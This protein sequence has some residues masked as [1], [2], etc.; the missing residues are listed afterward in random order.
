MTK[1]WE[2]ALHDKDFL[3]KFQDMFNPWSNDLGIA[4]TLQTGVSTEVDKKVSDALSE[5]IANQGWLS[6]KEPT[7]TSTKRDR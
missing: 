6:V 2:Q 3:P 4:L 1:N 7:K 5:R